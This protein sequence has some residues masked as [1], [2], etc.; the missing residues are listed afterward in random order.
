MSRRA[1]G[2]AGA[3]ETP[4]S[5]SRVSE[6]SGMVIVVDVALV[7]SW[8]AAWGWPLVGPPSRRRTRRAALE[9]RQTGARCVW[10]E[11]VGVVGRK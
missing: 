10:P 8:L 6:A 2:R 3:R 7:V 1:D 5:M 11:R 4:R 9:S